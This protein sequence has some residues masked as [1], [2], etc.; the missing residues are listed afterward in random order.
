MTENNPFKD[1]SA[2]SAGE[3]DDLQLGENLKG[4]E[5]LRTVSDL[6]LVTPE[7]LQQLPRIRDL[8]VH[9]LNDLASEFSGIA[10]GNDRVSSLSLDD[11]QDLEGV[12]FEFKRNVGSG[13]VRRNGN[14]RSVDVSCCCC[15]PCCSCAAA[16]MSPV[17]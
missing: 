5:Q 2:G 1:P 14:I 10:T 13:L 17:S 11:L 3:P 12:F 4:K 6:G 16:D 7:R 9:D 15:T 8:T